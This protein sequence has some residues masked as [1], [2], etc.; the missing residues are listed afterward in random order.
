MNL[1]YLR[2][3]LTVAEYEH[4]TRAA[5][6]LIISQPAVTKTIQHLEQE[7]GLELIERHGRRI[8]LTHAGR[9]LRD[10]GRRVFALEREMEDA[11][12]ALRDV[13]AGEVT[14]AANTTIGVYLLPPIVARFHARYPQVSLHISI[15][16][17]TE[18][19]EQTL[20]WNLDFGLVEIDASAVPAGLEMEVLDHDKLV[21]VVAPNHPWRGLQTLQPE[22]L[23][24]AELLLREQGSGIREVIEHALLQHDVQVRPLLTVPDNEAIKQMVMNG[25]GA[26]IVPARTVQRELATG[27]LLHIPIDG[28]DLRPELSLVRRTDKQL[29]RAAQAFCDLL[30]AKKGD[31][32]Y[33]T[34]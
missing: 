12:A 9:V 29:S 11:L 33:L 27:D 8:A 19:L 25:V 18:I 20:N 30:R 4:I 34:E 14:L 6:E 23:Q 1:H 17:S 7:V 22:E 28:L 31:E 3:F 26:A 10:Y 13:D 21:L 15:L 5:E 32:Q 16:N 24:D 2:V